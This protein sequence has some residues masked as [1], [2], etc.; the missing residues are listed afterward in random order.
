MSVQPLNREVP[1]KPPHA[2]VGPSFAQSCHLVLGAG[3]A[4]LLM[5]GW[6]AF[7]TVWAGDQQ[8]A[9][10]QNASPAVHGP[11]SP[12]LS[13]QQIEL[14]PDLQIELVA[15]EPQVIDPVAMAW[16][17]HGRLWVVEMIDYPNGPAEGEQPRSRI[18]ILQDQDGDGYYETSTIFADN[19]LFANSVYPWKGGVIVTLAGELA[20]FRDTTGDG[21]ADHRETWFSG[22]SE[23]NPQLRANHPRL[24]LDN[25][26]YVANGLRG[27]DVIARRPE[28]S[29][30]AEPVSISGMD[31]RFDPFTGKYEAVSGMGQFG[32]TFDDFGN[33]FVC[34]NRNPSKH[35]VLEDH[36]IKRNPHLIV[37]SVAEDV[38]PPGDA[39]RV[40][41]ITEAWTTS[42]LHAG[43]FTAACGVQIYRGDLLPE[44]FRG[45][46]FTCEPTGHLVHR[47]VL[48][49]QGPTFSSRYGR[50]GVEFLASR[51]DWFRPVNLTNGPDGAFYVIDMYRAV[52]E[53]PQF[54]PAELK[55]RPDLNDGNDRGRIYRIVPKKAAPDRKA[56][57]PVKLADATAG[58][59]VELLA[60]S[61][62]WQR[63]TA[64]RLLL[65]RQDRSVGKSLE[66]LAR[67]GKT[68]QARI[69][70][71]WLLDGLGLLTKPIVQ[72]A[73]EDEHTRVAE[74]AVLLAERWLEDDSTLREAVGS[75]AVERDDVRLDF[76]ILLSLG[77]PRNQSERTLFNNIGLAHAD[78]AW[79]RTAYASVITMA[80]ADWFDELA[81][82][83][84]KSERVRAAGVDELFEMLAEV[85]GGQQQ[86]DRIITAL[87]FLGGVTSAIVGNRV[88]EDEAEYVAA[89]NVLFAGID[90]LGRGSRRRGKTLASYAVDLPQMRANDVRRTFEYAARFAR[91]SG[92]DP[93][94]RMRTL[95]VLRHANF[96][97]AQDALM[98]L[99]LN[100]PDQR[101]R[102]AAID[103]LSSFAAPEIGPAL[104]AEFTAQTP[105]VRRAILDAM[106]NNTARTKLLLDE[107]EA[108]TIAI[109]EL[110]PAR[111]NRLSR[112]RDADI[113]KQAEKL[114]AAATP[115]DRKSVLAEYQQAL[116]V[117]A[118]PQRGREVFVKN[119]TACHKIGDVG[120]N[121][122]PDIA[123]SR[124]KTPAQLLTDILDPNRAVD[125]NYFTYAVVTTE[126]QVH[127]GIIASETAS[128]I[129]L[130]QAENKSVSILRQDVEEMRSTGQSLMPVGLEKN[131]TVE[132]MADLISFIKNWRYLDG[133]VPLSDDG[134]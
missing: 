123:D 1:P 131:I 121:V 63:E 61:N 9:K 134:R 30:G 10:T 111:T 85:L 114:L 126:G 25:R 106:L 66:T 86:A 73:L 78:D 40:F 6:I 99:A 59:L 88:G 39:S 44:E 12:K 33:R 105:P 71:L 92:A 45:N 58:E 101:V 112:H 96:E 35:V 15:A 17:E 95:Q 98:E 124:T 54:M 75:L 50:E 84:M 4:V 67:E 94:L 132:Q 43:Q 120:V 57:H 13:M 81:Q 110:D 36:Y 19:L 133:R 127:T 3:M 23:Q 74:Q 65:E 89:L 109:T 2:R 27:G 119:C 122:A 103:V 83:L 22:F 82:E 117:P 93:K 129:T 49:P 5:G 116:S 76:Q 125:S 130:R 87:S 90:G 104:L 64:A 29:E 118:D 70:A 7:R 28:W 107:I 18:R 77:V 62:A 37:R 68:P 53:H 26:F 42:T 72:R 55:E 38:S 31:F 20:Y 91:D 128:S 102:L 100:E 11:M 16:D 24:G 48:T 97:T 51:D 80:E 56:S 52:I 60:H 41:A 108:G 47:D 79:M 14:H 32:L 69:R 115:A 21:K 113:R 34:S 8:A 46:S